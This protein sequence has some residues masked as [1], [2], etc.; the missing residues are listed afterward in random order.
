VAFSEHETVLQL[1]GRPVIVNTFGCRLT[2]DE[3][4]VALASIKSAFILLSDHAREFSLADTMTMHR[5]DEIIVPSSDQ[6][7]LGDIGRNPADGR[8]SIAVSLAYMQAVSTEWIAAL[9]M[10]EMTHLE[11][12]GR[13][14]GPDLWLSE[15]TATARQLGVMRALGAPQSELNYLAYWGSVAN[16][17]AMQRHMEGGFVGPPLEQP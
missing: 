7:G 5:L 1:I 16:R 12:R 11:L 2:L 4:Q 10:H 17:I 15:R 3:E 9:P 6:I 14:F 13:Y 8:T